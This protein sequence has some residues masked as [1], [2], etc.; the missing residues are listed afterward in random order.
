MTAGDLGEAAVDAGPPASARSDADARLD[1]SHNGRAEAHIPGAW[2]EELLD[3]ALSVP[4]DRGAVAAATHCLDVLSRLLPTMAVG[5]CLVR[6]NSNEPLIVTRVPAGSH[7]GEGRDPTRLF[8]AAA[9][10]RIFRVADTTGGSTLHLAVDDAASI[11]RDATCWDLAGRGARVLG[12]ALQRADAFQQARESRAEFERLQAHVIQ[13]E[14]LASLGQI[15]AGVVH[16]LNNPLTSIVAY[17]DYLKK[18]MVASGDAGDAERL[19]RI[20]EAAERILRFSRDLVAYSR[21]ASGIPGPVQLEDVV[22][23]AIVFCEHEFTQNRVQVEREYDAVVPPVRG[24]AGQLTQ[25]FVNLFTNAAHAMSRSGGRLRITMHKNP[26]PGTVLVHV[27]D[28]GVG[29]AP[30]DFERIFEPFFTTKA[31]GRGAG[32]GLSIVSDIVAAHGGT[33][34]AQSNVGEGSVFSVTLPLAAMGGDSADP[35]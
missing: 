10:E 11:T 28:E 24:F 14:K 32:L 30:N 27:S 18:K 25:V 31:D 33:L 7:A 6:P 9:A 16:E 8:P 23:K 22:E 29:I 20:S 34:E 19:Q 4:V 12:V 26:T 5:A 3:L 35:E 2:F 21:P 13:A 17:S 1:Q 15:V